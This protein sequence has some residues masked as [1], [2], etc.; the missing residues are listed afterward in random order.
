[1][2]LFVLIRT[3]AEVPFQF[4]LKALKISLEVFIAIFTL[5]ILHSSALIRSSNL[6]DLFNASKKVERGIKV[7]FITFIMGVVAVISM[8]YGYYIAL[9][10]L[11]TNINFIPLVV[12]LVVLGTILIFTSCVSVMIYISKKNEKSLFKGTKLISTAQL[13]YRYKGNVGTLSIIALASTV[14]L[15]AL[16]TCVGTYSKNEENSRYMRPYSIEYYNIN[17]GDNVFDAVLKKHSE[18]SVK[19]K[20]NIEMLKTEISDPV[21]SVKQDFY[22][23]GE[24]EFNTANKHEN[25]DR[26]ANLKAEEC[27]FIQ[28][29]NFG[30]NEK[31]LGKNVAFK[32]GNEDYSLKI[33]A[34]DMKPFIGMD[35][36]NET[37]VVKDS[38]YNDMKAKG[39]NAKVVNITG[40]VLDNDFKAESFIKELNG[41]FSKDSNLLSFYD[42]YKDGLKLLGMMA[43]IGLFIG[44]L[45]ITATGSIIYFKMNM[46]AREDRSKFIMLSKIGVSRKEIKSGVAKELLLLFGA[47]LVIAAANTYPASVALGGMLAMNMIQSY[48]IIVILYAAVYCIYYFLTLNSYMKAIE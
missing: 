37:I 26:E 3:P 45:F 34:T 13:Y 38:V 42:H 29:Q 7:S 2:L 14:A 24:S 8:G 39:G 32:L 9:K 17:D 10:K 47:P 41:K 16:V 6:I 18:V 40:Y 22:I 27:Y 33:A 30:T 43:F 21:S 4:S 44:I 31:A 20:D 36:F 11:S 15:V 25:V 28:I 1:M 46:E 48:I 19:Y 35:H 5:T 23:M 12:F